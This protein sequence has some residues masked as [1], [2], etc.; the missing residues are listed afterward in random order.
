MNFTIVCVPFQVD[1]ARWGCAAGPKAFLDAGIVQQ[2]E[3]RE[4]TVRRVVEIDLPKAERTRDGVTNLGRIAGHTAQAIK[5]ALA[6]EDGFVLALEGDCTH[7]VG[8]IGGLAQA[9]GAPGVVWFDAHGDMNTM[10]TSTTGFLGGLP[11]GV[12]LGLDLEDWRLAAG[13]D[14]AVRPQAAALIGTSDLDTAEV[15]IL[16][17]HPILHIDARQLMEGDVA[18]R[19]QAALKPRSAEAK[20]WYMHLDLDVAG[21][22]ELPGGMTPA[23]YWPP[24]HALIECVGAAARSVKVNVLSLAVYNPA[25]DSD[26]RGLRLGLDMS[27][28]AIDNL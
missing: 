5:E 20:G 18:E 17:H 23:P 11:Y 8:A 26:G 10:E 16:H 13:L 28:A 3:A 27:M 12:A 7:A 1:V 22:E 9:K 24:R 21:P 25:L 19:V 6:E 2:I 15:E 14:R 4:H